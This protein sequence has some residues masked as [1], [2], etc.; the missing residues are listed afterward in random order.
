MDRSFLRGNRE[1]SLVPCGD[2]APMGRSDKERSHTA[3]MHPTED[4]DDLVVP[5]KRA[6]TAKTSVAASVEERGSTR[7]TVNQMTSSRTL[8][9]TE[10]G[11]FGWQRHVTLRGQR[12]VTGRSRTRLFRT[13]G[14]VRGVARKGHSCRDNQEDPRRAGVSVFQ[15]VDFPLPVALLQ[16]TSL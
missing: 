13:S 15:P 9:R 14:S 16:Q 12:T 8:T 4:S 2:H 1:A 5:S 3:D 6:N 10:E 11:L 7:G